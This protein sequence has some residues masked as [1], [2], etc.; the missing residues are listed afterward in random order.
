MMPEGDTESHAYVICLLTSV[1]LFLLCPRRCPGE[2]R[3]DGGRLLSV[4]SAAAG[5]QREEKD[6]QTGECPTC[7]R[8]TADL[9]RR[10]SPCSPHEE[11]YCPCSYSLIPQGSPPYLLHSSVSDCRNSGSCCHK[12]TDI[13]YFWILRIVA[14]LQSLQHLWIF[15]IRTSQSRNSRLLA[16][17]RSPFY[18]IYIVNS[19]KKKTGWN[20]LVWNI[21]ACYL[22]PLRRRDREQPECA[23]SIMLISGLFTYSGHKNG[24]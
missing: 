5:G 9:Q 24:G 1:H 10:S 4:F 3:E 6:A 19:L 14:D 8:R 18:D 23:E 17:N 15:V 16:V 22:L 7:R 13:T 2:R 12:F 11:S 21:K 20:M